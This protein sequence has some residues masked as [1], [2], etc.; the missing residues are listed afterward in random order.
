V[1][2]LSRFLCVGLVPALF[3]TGCAGPRPLKGGKAVTTRK[4]AGV[5]E[6]TLVQGEE[7]VT[8]DEADPGNR[9]SAHLHRAHRLP[10]RATPD[11]CRSPT[12]AAAK[13]AKSNIRLGQNG[14]L[15]GFRLFAKINCTLAQFRHDT[16]L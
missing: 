6:Q 10:T 13:E 1:D 15:S 2:Y 9:E 12:M 8:T 11:A 3:A 16:W 14:T 5:I 4:P 7:S